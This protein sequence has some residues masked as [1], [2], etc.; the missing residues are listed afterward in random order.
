MEVY[1]KYYENYYYKQS[2]DSLDLNFVNNSVEGS[3]TYPY[4]DGSTS[5]FMNN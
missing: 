5:S 4:I 1:D 3:I 2:L